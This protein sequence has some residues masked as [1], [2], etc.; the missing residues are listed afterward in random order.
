M[1]TLLANQNP[2]HNVNNLKSIGAVGLCS[3]IASRRPLIN[4]QRHIVCEGARLS[5]LTIR[6]AQVKFSL[7]GILGPRE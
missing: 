7:N 5:T 3:G 1:I 2:N 6:S 4:L